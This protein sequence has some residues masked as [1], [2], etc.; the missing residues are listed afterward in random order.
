MVN[1]SLIANVANKQCDRKCNTEHNCRTIK[2]QTDH[3]Q[4]DRPRHSGRTIDPDHIATIDHADPKQDG[5][6]I[7]KKQSKI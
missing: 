6:K 3:Q 1:R 7:A 2:N 5:R 4:I